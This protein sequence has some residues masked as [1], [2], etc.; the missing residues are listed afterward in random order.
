MHGD[1][2]SRTLMKLDFSDNNSIPL[3]Q[4]LCQV[5]NLYLFLEYF[6]QTGELIVGALCYLRLYRFIFKCS[7]LNGKHFC[8]L[9]FI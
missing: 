1:S 3:T 9:L 4:H 7:F 2:T 5:Y 6:V 8:L